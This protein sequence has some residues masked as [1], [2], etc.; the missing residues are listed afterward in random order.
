MSAYYVWLHT[1]NVKYIEIM[2]EIDLEEEVCFQTYNYV[3]IYVYE[4]FEIW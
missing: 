4:Y 3:F 2:N 1:V